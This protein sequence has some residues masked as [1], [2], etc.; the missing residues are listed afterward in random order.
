MARDRGEL[1]R[2]SLGRPVRSAPQFR[3][4]IEAWEVPKKRTL[5]YLIISVMSQRPARPAKYIR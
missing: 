3:P 2:K 5:N 1:P 4:F